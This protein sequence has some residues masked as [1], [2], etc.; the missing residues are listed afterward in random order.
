MVVESCVAGKHTRLLLD[1][2]FSA[3]ELDKRLAV[4]GLAATD[5]NAVLITHEHH[6]HAAGAYRVAKRW[7]LPLYA[8]YGTLKAAYDTNHPEWRHH[9]SLH[10]I[11]P[12]AQ[13]AIGDILLHAIAVP[14]DAHEPVQY[15]FE[16]GGRHLAVLTDAGHASA[17]LK[18]HLNAITMCVCC[19]NRAIRRVLSNVLAA[20]GAIYRMLKPPICCPAL[21]RSNCIVCGAPI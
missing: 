18:L 10:L 15:R 16:S 2:G 11:V 19:N 14:H 1:C 5:L 12:D 8:T 6:D 9:P 7:R 20:T 3:K 13:F 4:L 21:I 17:H